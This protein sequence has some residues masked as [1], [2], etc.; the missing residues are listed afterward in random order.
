MMVV[1][2]GGGGGG[3]EGGGRVL[4]K[5]MSEKSSCMKICKEKVFM[6]KGHILILNRKCSKNATKWH[7]S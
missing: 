3:G 2:V 4:G 1:V 7:Y 5:I 6:H